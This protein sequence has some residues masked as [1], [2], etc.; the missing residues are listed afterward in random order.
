[1][2]S[3][4]CVLI[5][6]SAASDGRRWSFSFV[7]HFL[8]GLLILNCNSD[9]FSSLR[10]EQLDNESLIATRAKGGYP[11]RWATKGHLAIPHGLSMTHPQ[12]TTNLSHPRI[13]EILKVT[14]Y[15]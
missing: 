4:H 11:A 8:N 12:P 9:H 10:L 15:C 7:T 2:L 5:S 6:K 1:M 3:K 13:P 14:Y